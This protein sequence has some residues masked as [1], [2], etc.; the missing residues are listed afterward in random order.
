MRKP[1]NAWWCLGRNKA[2]TRGLLRSNEIHSYLQSHAIKNEPLFASKLA[3][4]IA[5]YH[6][7]DEE[8]RL[9]IENEKRE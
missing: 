3:T 7:L 2:N 8:Y 6:A 9:K 4:L 5:K 1:H